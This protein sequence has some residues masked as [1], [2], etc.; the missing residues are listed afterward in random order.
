MGL[1]DSLTTKTD[2]ALFL[3]T[4]IILRNCEA[5]TQFT[6]SC[7]ACMQDPY[8]L[9]LYI[10]AK[11]VCADGLQLSTIKRAEKLYPQIKDYMLYLQGNYLLNHG[12]FAKTEGII[13]QLKKINRTLFIRLLSAYTERLMQYREYSQYI[14]L[15]K[16]IR[17]R[18]AYLFYSYIRALKALH[19]PYTN[20]LTRFF[21]IYGNSSYAVY[22]LSYINTYKEYMALPLFNACR[23]STII[24]MYK[25]HKFKKSKYIVLYLK[26][27][28]KLRKYKK[29]NEELQKTWKK[30]KSTDD[31]NLLLLMSGFAYMRTGYTKKGLDRFLF[32]SANGERGAVTEFFYT[33]ASMPR[34]KID[35]NRYFLSA[36]D[37]I[38]DPCLSFYAGIWEAW[39]GDTV[40]G[41]HYLKKSLNR[42]KTHYDTLKAVYFIKKFHGKLKKDL[43][44]PTDL[45]YYNVKSGISLSNIPL[46]YLIDSIYKKQSKP[47]AEK[48]SRWTQLGVFNE[49]RMIEKEMGNNAHS[50]Y[51]M[52]NTSRSLGNDGESIRLAAKLR[53]LLAKNV[54]KFPAG[55][56]QFY[57]PLSYFKKVR[58]FSDRLGI[59]PV[60]FLSL[61]REES[62]FSPSAISPQGAIGI[63][64]LMYRTAR[65]VAGDSIYIK[66]HSLF[67]PDTN[68]YI[69]MLYFKQL[70]DSFGNPALSA[71]AYNAGEKRLKRWKNDL[72]TDDLETFLEFIPITETREYVKRIIRTYHIYSYLLKGVSLKK[73]G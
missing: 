23:Y 28:Y 11:S 44:N 60:F 73:E 59:D 40:L 66:R 50:I 19:L 45:T 29:F 6:D 35:L 27:L 13:W 56:M 49:W 36:F 70:K 20:Q 18:N 17:Y 71:A 47:S 22:L 72:Y 46:G 24:S 55:F 9:L 68:I 7:S 3:Q 14:N 61:M 41:L 53:A 12:E 65:M 57:F 43:D 30:V 16:E 10:R 25:K 37:F 39:Q 58:K 2:T 4:A 42:A 64:Q 26:S 38:N 5:I 62:L 69:G 8:L 21:K 1:R 63:S 34:G 32:A 54:K 33:I 15:Y 31:M 48:K 67:N 52:M 51:F